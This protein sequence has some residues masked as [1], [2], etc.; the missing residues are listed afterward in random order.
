VLTKGELIDTLIPL[1]N[2]FKNYNF[3]FIK[4]EDVKSN[5][6]I[7]IRDYVFE[8]FNSGYLLIVASEKTI[9]PYPLT[10]TENDDFTPKEV[11]T[12]TFYGIEDI[13]FDRDSNLGEFYDDIMKLV[14]NSGS[15]FQEFLLTQKKK[16]KIT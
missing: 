14:L 7:E 4:L 5:D 12:D 2:E 8:K 1:Q 13:N 3:F 10:I 16:L 6:P 9:P 11:E 15:L